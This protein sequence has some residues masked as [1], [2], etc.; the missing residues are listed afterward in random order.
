MNTRIPARP[1]SAYSAAE[2]VSPEVAR[3][4][5]RKAEQVEPGLEPPHR[6]D[7]VAAEGARGVRSVDDPL[8]IGRR[9]VVD[10]ARQ[11]LERERAVAEPSPRA[12][13][14]AVDARI[15]PGRR[16][17]A[18]GRETF[19]Q[20]VGERGRRHP[21]ARRNVPH[22]RLDSIFSSAPAPRAGCG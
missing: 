20:D 14:R 2:P 16:Q 18:V 5:V 13:R 11:D 10:V 17:A 21:A 9:N 22:R 4:P 15:R 8:E 19:E 7:V 3:R 12:E 6:R 1:R